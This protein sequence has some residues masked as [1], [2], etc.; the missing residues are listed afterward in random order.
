MSSATKII[1]YQYDPAGKMTSMTDPEGGRTTY[2]YDS[3]NRIS[4]LIN[5]QLERTSFLFDANGREIQKK[6]SNGMRTS[7]LYDSTSNILNISEFKSNNSLISNFTYEYD[8][9]G[10]RIA[11]IEADN[12]RTTWSYDNVYQL[13]EEH[14]TGSYPFKNSFEY[15]S[16]GNRILK[17]ENGSVTTCSYDIANQLTASDAPVGRTTYLYDFNGNQLV[18]E[19]PSGDRNTITWNYDNKIMGLET[20]SGSRITNTYEPDGLRIKYED[21]FE[22]IKNVWDNQNCLIETN[23]NNEAQIFYTYNPKNYGE[24]ISAYK[25]EISSY[26]H[27]DVLGS[28][29][30][31]TDSSET[32]L[33]SY[34]Y[35]AWGNTIYNS[36]STPNNFRW[37][38]RD[39]YY[40]DELS[41][42][43]YVRSRTYSPIT[44]RWLSPDPMTFI[45]GVNFYVAYFV[46]QGED[47]SGYSIN[48]GS[49]EPDSNCCKK[50][51]PLWQYWNYTSQQ[52]C[53][54]HQLLMAAMR[55]GGKLFGIGA[56][57]L[58]FVRKALSIGNWAS[59]I[60]GVGATLVVKE[61]T[62]RICGMQV[63]T[64]GN[65]RAPICDNYSYDYLGLWRCYRINCVCPV[66]SQLWDGKPTY[67]AYHDFP[68]WDLDDL[69]GDGVK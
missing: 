36:G 43:Y 1:K 31:L 12:S 68:S 11:C 24:L 4:S 66:G 48:T 62:E 30:N 58:V 41:S 8:N 45:D 47:P 28:T 69:K 57:G 55:P 9:A 37:L 61:G 39:G 63:C 49:A 40:Y 50:P 54:S 53:V 2:T 59:I 65:M 16:T 19:F 42:S 18:S 23:E 14:R 15:D 22:V 29:R 60:A 34:L 7:F 35:D 25:D 5:P 67:D 51:E 3:L 56:T 32:I 64:R 52:E 20:L 44:G 10:N 6:M 13:K 38:G 33:N 27:Y 26:Y 17:N 46:P 21:T